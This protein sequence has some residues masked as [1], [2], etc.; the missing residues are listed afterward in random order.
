MISINN[1][2]KFL[3]YFLPIS[4][5]IG[6]AAVNI[7]VSLICVLIIYTLIK[8]KKNYYFINKYFIFF[9]LWCLYL[10]LLSITS[11]H[12]LL[13]LGGS[14]FYFRFGLLV[15]AMYY[16]SSIDENFNYYFFISLLFCFSILIFDTFIQNIF[17]KNIFGMYREDGRISS[18]FGSELILGSYLS[19]L[20]P[21]FLALIFLVKKN[22]KNMFYL[23]VFYT[24]LTNIVIFI[25]GERT[26]YLINVLSIFLIFILISKLKKT[27]LFLS[28]A[29]II[30][31]SLVIF[32]SPKIRLRMVYMPLEQINLF[33]WDDKEYI[34][35][36]GEL[37]LR[38]NISFFS[39]QHEVLYKTAYNIFKDNKIFGIGPKNFR[40]ICKIKKYKTLTI[41]DASVKGCDTSPHNIYI[42]LLTETGIIGTIPIIFIFSYLFFILV[43]CFYF[44]YIKKE[45]YLLDHQICLCVLVFANLWPIMPTGNFFNSYLN[46]IYYLPLGFLIS[47]I[48]K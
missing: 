23:F 32:I 3:L 2:N 26:A 48:K 34:S 37:V 29:I 30:S 33:H 12:I 44:K 38:K 39:A 15:L 31:I 40:E 27:R 28:L 45:I 41:L 1:I 36:N 21:L 17:D 18:F 35:D 14:L 20:F 9:I 19:R 11:D 24:I 7:L 6:S 42:Q 8:E 43:K 47:I 13:S 5:I 10:I 16:F 25:S 46:T 4:L 22:K